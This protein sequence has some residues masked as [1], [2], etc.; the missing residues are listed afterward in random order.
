[1]ATSFALWT[2][3]PARISLPA[4]GSTLDPVRT[5]TA[6]GSFETTAGSQAA[7]PGAASRT[8]ALICAAHGVS[9]FH[10]LVLP[11]LFP[12]LRD[13]LGV[14]FIELGLALTVFNVVTGLTQAP[15]GFIVDRFGAKRILI[16]G[17]VLGGVAFVSLGFVHNFAWLLVASAMGGLANAVYHPADYAIMAAEIDETRMGRAFSL[18]TFSGFFGGAVAPATVL[19][20]ASTLGLDAA[21]IAAGA[22]GLVVAAALYW[23]APVGAGA[24][25][26]RPAAGTAPAA[27]DAPL[28]AL[29]SPAIL[30]LTAFFALISLS[31][32][33]IMNFSVVA[34][35]DGRGTDLVVANMALTAFLLASAFGVLCGGFL[36][37]KTKHHGDIA[38]A[39]FGLTAL[40]V[41]LVMLMPLPSLVL[42]VVMGT[43]GFL[44]GTI[45]PSRDM[46][47]RAAAPP[48]ASGRVFGIVTTGFNIGGA[49]GPIVFGWIM[50]RGEPLWVFGATVAFMAMTTGVALVSG[51]RARGKPSGGAP[52]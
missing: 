32:G 52:A 50:D 22:V 41:L 7:A 40:L 3:G 39:G 19:V 51:R 34:L 28:R 49:L 8:L 5:M 29:L 48:G 23:F 18:H 14:G 37:D 27:P 6:T 12:F 10:I 17:L 43:A 26:Q 30:S 36:A 11:P 44:A 2:I 1:M 46:L 35:V 9:H 13:A 4:R 20:L 25:R 31:Q 15:M 47:V 16:A 24:A 45:A 38:A 33:G 42:I 21:L